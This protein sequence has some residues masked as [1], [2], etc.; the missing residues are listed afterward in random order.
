MDTR[1]DAVPGPILSSR[2]VSRLRQVKPRLLLLRCNYA[3]L[4][5][6]TDLGFLVHRSRSDVV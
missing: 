4:P 1:I 6:K 2:R 3:W 5:H